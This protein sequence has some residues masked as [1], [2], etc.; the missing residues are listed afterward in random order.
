MG[1][2]LAALFI[3]W[4]V[5]TLSAG[6]FFPLFASS[7]APTLLRLGLFV[8]EVGLITALTGASIGQRL[9]AIRVATYPQGHFLTPARAFIRTFLI[10]LVLPPLI[11]DSQGRGLHERLTQSEVIRIYR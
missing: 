2:R 7:L 6:I 9:L 8:F 1:R 10:A 4:M 5:A 11:I 3:D